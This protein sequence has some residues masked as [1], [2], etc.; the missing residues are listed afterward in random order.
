MSNKREQPRRDPLDGTGVPPYY[1]PVAAVCMCCALVY[2]L[3]FVQLG[4]IS[5]ASTKNAEGID[6][7]PLEEESANAR[8]KASASPPAEIRRTRHEL[9]GPSAE[10]ARE[11]SS[12]AQLKRAIGAFENKGYNVSFVLR[13]LASEQ[14]ISYD[15]ERD[16]YPA[17]SIKGPYVT[18]LFQMQVEPGAVP[19]DDVSELV[20][21]TVLY[22]DNDAYREL[23]E[24]YGGDTFVQWLRDAG[25]NERPYVTFEDFATTNYPRICTRQLAQMWMHVNAYLSSG[26][27]LAKQL[28][29]LFLTREVAP[30]R[31]AISS[32]STIS[33]GKAGWMD[34]EDEESGA[35]PSTTE[36]GIIYT[37]EGNFLIVLMSDAPAEFDDVLPIINALYQIRVALT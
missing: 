13:N 21:L 31:D 33:I 19:I 8:G 24:L 2:T 22:S 32:T 9:E 23:R 25:V 30:M 6:E 36:A 29:E 4:G 27:D 14:E 35:T 1:L 16:Y 18:S 34:E 15:A 37:K 20:A 7:I 5:W 3:A 10:T 17:S 26:T 28:R 11:T 12:Y